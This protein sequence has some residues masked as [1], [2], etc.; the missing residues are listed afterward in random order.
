MVLKVA[1]ARLRIDSS[2]YTAIDITEHVKKLVVDQGLRD[3]VVLVYTPEKR[4][5]I[6]LIEYEPNLLAD[7][8]DLLKRIGCIDI[9]VCDAII[10][11]SVALPAIRGS[12][13]LGMFKRIVFIDLSKVG[14]EKVVVIVLEGVFEAS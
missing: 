1:L 4:C 3:G 5:S 8:E 7:L 14:G 12:L 10:G 6:T 11:K 13:E 9:G 2:G